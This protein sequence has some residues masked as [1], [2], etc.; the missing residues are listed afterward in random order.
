MKVK[1]NR[2]SIATITLTSEE[3]QTL[4][5]TLHTGVEKLTTNAIIAKAMGS[6]LEESSR[7]LAEEAK[8]VDDAL[9][10]AVQEWCHTPLKK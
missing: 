1:M 7:K 2:R 4:R 6:D 10:A 3:L 5:S 8:Q 9:E